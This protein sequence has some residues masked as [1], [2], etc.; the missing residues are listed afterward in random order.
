MFLLSTIL[1]YSFLLITVIPFVICC[2]IINNKGRLVK[3]VQLYNQSQRIKVFD[4]ESGVYIIN[5]ITED[6]SIVT[7][8][9][10]IKK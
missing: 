10:L 3:E 1:K 9:K 8:Q 7:S 4:L 6:K 5:L 2:Q